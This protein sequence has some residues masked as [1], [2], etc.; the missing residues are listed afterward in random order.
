MYFV[1]LF[2]NM[3]D[4]FISGDKMVLSGPDFD[5][6]AVFVK[7]NVVETSATWD[8]DPEIC[9]WKNSIWGVTGKRH[10]TVFVPASVVT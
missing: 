8:I 4:T 2:N 3:G 1:K 10:I 9:L 7:D 6:L 5:K